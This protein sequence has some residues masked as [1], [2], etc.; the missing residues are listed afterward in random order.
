MKGQLDP[1]KHQFDQIK[2]TFDQDIL[3]TCRDNDVKYKKFLDDIGKLF[4]SDPPYILN[5]GKYTRR[6]QFALCKD[7]NLPVVKPN[8]KNILCKG[9]LLNIEEEYIVITTKHRFFLRN[10]WNTISSKYWD[11][12][13]KLS[14]KYKLVILGEKVVEMSKEYAQHGSN[15]TYSIYNEIIANL[16]KDRVIDLTVQALGITSPELEKIQQ[17][18][19]IMSEARFVIILGTGGA[20]CMATSVA[21][22]IGHRTDIDPLYEGKTY[23]DSYITTSFNNFI[24][25]LEQHL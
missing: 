15:I 21:N 5:T 19:L 13:N 4:F 17:D 3:E 1:F 16:P 24:N 6:G 22:T 20:F 2:I 9:S 8:L 7:Y 25:K 23:E 11:T 10:Y 18:C 14:K 12:L